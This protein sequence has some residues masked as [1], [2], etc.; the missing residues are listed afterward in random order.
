M[1]KKILAVLISTV[2]ICAIITANIASAA[3]E[4]S[5]NYEPFVLDESV[6]ITSTLNN[7]TGVLTL[8]WSKYAHAEE[9]KYYMVVRSEINDN[10]VYPDDGYLYYSDNINVLSYVDYDVLDG[11]HYYRVCHIAETK[12]YCSRTVII[13]DKAEEAVPEIDP[14]NQ[15]SFFDLAADHW[16][17]ECIERLVDEEIVSGNPDGS[18]KPD[19]PVN[20]A[21]FVKMVILAMYPELADFEASACFDDVAET[22][23]FAPYVCASKS[24]KVVE[25]YDG[26]V[27]K[28]GERM[29]R[30]EATSVLV[31]ALGKPVS[32]NAF[33]VFDD[34]TIVWEI[35][36][37]NAASKYNLVTGYDDGTFRPENDIAR[38]EA[39]KLICN[40]LDANAEE[41][42]EGGVP[43]T[44]EL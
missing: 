41:E 34:V 29:T 43:R 33:S 24:K 28:P 4:D 30:A 7:N 9:F 18:F 11:K 6:T 25:G 39:A 15:S 10:P 32:M 23:W 19:N 35:E 17:T 42:G 20:R 22:D 13:V 26:N 21:E 16:A 38:T 40:A 2:S 37:I 14:E 27:F 8:N 44:T 5:T 12:R 1:N 3:L 36:Y 31:K